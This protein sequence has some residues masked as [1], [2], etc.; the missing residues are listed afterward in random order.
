[1][2]LRQ[3]KSVGQTVE[4]VHQKARAAVDP[5][6]DRIQVKGGTPDQQALLATSLLHLFTMPTDMS[7]DGQTTAIGTPALTDFICLWD[8]IRN[9]NSLFHLI[10]P[11]FSAD[12]MNSLLDNADKT[13]WLPDAHLAGQFSPF[14]RAV[15]ARKFSF[16]RRRE[17]ELP[18]STTAGPSPP[19][20]ATRKP[21]RRIPTTL[22]AISTTTKSWA[23]SPPTS[24]DHA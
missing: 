24:N 5:W 22:G 10:A 12:I 14:S 13:G 20:S 19:V 8:S 7:A 3:M 23:T 11:E 4:V 16:P 21:P 1:M 9:A 15:A 6:L 17:R 18:A 2:R